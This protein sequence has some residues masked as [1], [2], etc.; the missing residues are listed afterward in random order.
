MK[1]CKIWLKCLNYSSHFY[2]GLEY[3]LSFVFVILF[4]LY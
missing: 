3:I 2:I 4:I 1:G